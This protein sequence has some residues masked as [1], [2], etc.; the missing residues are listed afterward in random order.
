MKAA[1]ATNLL[2]ALMNA[3]SEQDRAVR[4]ALGLP[5]SERRHG[6][7]FVFQKSAEAD[8]TL[9]I[10]S[11]I[12]REIVAIRDEW[13][14]LKSA[15]A[16]LEQMQSEKLFAFTNK[17]DV[18]SFRILCAVLAHGDVAKASRTLN[19]P[20][21]TLRSRMNRW[22]DRG[23]AY[24]VLSELVRWRKAM[25]NKGTVSV[26][27]S[28]TQGTAAPADFAG[29]LSDVLDEVLT[30]TEDNWNEK[31]EALAELLRPHVGR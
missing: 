2:F 23:P 16:R 17:I 28:I 11:D 18:E 27:E 4:L 31:A 14:S 6:E 20:A 13:Q 22:K 9:E 12:H 3:T 26:N 15:K 10:V 24:Q 21:T 19:A 30:M 25:G 5:Y 29:L 8:R 1:I 7:K